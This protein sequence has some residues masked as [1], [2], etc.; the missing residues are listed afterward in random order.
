MIRMNEEK[1]MNI[2]RLKRTLVVFLVFMLAACESGPRVQMAPG[3][4]AT[5]TPI[6]SSANVMGTPAP[7]SIPPTPT[8]PS[9]IQDKKLYSLP[10]LAFSFYP[11][12]SWTL[13]NEDESYAKFTSPDQT[14]WM[15]AAVES[16]G[17]ELSAEDFQTYVDNMLTSLYSGAKEYKLLRREDS[18]GKTLV[19]SVF[20]KGEQKWYSMDAFYQRGQALYALS[21]QAYETVWNIYKTTFQEIAENVTTQSG[22]LRKEHTYQ[23]HRTIQSPS[24][25]YKITIPLGWSPTKDEEGLEGGVI[26]TIASPDNEAGAEMITIN[27]QELLAKTD[28]GQISIGLIKERF[29]ADLG[30]LNDEVLEDGRIRTDWKNEKTKISG[31]SFFWLNG[32]ELNILTFRFTDEHPGIYQDVLKGI[33]NSF[34]F[35]KK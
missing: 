2:M 24:G 27:A 25:V 22:Y 33:S 35:I 30:F 8:I 5:A 9:L 32:Y 28:I 29:G 6:R 23:F 21:F 18:G 7:T 11:P 15:E 1:K 17:Y 16:S 19:S 26:E 4:E 13:I 34:A 10:S 12:K 14:A 31:F 20:M 3:Y